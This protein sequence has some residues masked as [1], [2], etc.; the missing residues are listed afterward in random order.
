MFLRGASR[1]Q[2][3]RNLHPPEQVYTL[4][5]SP[6][7]WPGPPA[8]SRPW[9]RVQRG[10]HRRGVSGQAAWSP[11]ALASGGAG[12]RFGRG[13]PQKPSRRGPHPHGHYGGG[14]SG[15]LLR[16][17]ARLPFLARRW[18]SRRPHAVASDKWGEGELLFRLFIFGAKHHWLR[19]RISAF[20]RISQRT[21]SIYLRCRLRGLLCSHT[22][23]FT[24]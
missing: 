12:V 9:A 13:P 5:V 22:D 23:T 10:P 2:Q 24:F 16:P 4:C 18:R 17:P 6:W 15:L 19:Q 7:P 8:Q 20:S 1:G 3:H 21:S 14:C 11:W